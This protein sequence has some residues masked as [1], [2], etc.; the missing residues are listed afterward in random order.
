M[1]SSIYV[2]CQVQI[3]PHTQPNFW[4]LL[5]LTNFI[6]LPTKATTSQERNIYF[7]YTK[8]VELNG[9]VLKTFGLFYRKRN[10]VYVTLQFDV[11]FAL[12]GV[13]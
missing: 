6:I 2:T 5:S 9:K 10:Y 8:H 3:N 1:Y 4:N 11:C 12:Q 7:S 13:N